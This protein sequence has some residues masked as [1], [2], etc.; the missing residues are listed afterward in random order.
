MSRL[1][2][3]LLCIA[4]AEP[5]ASTDSAVEAPAEL[6]A[7]SDSVVKTASGPVVPA[8]S[9]V[10]TPT[11]P[12]DDDHDRPSNQTYGVDRLQSMLSHPHLRIMSLPNIYSLS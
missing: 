1:I 4:P 10:K 6:L 5:S 8:D 12:E 3:S 2:A 11:E 7:S 9:A